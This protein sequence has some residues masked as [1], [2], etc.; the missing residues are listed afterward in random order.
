MIS[1][2]NRGTDHRE[3]EDRE[4]D[5]ETDDRFRYACQIFGSA[6]HMGVLH[7][8]NYRTETE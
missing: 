5:R 6:A 3:S 1:T 4:E 8:M 7:R 2:V